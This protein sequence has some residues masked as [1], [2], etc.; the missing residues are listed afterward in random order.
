MYTKEEFLKEFLKTLAE[1]QK[2]SGQT[3]YSVS[4]KLNH[5]SDYFSKVLKGEKDLKLSEFCQ[6]CELFHITPREFFE[7]EYPYRKVAYRKVYEK[8]QSFSP[9]SFGLLRDFVEMLSLYEEKIRD[10]NRI[11]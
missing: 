9:D 7:D 5:P 11:S 2:L 6:I 1:K 8:I 10:K 3:R 4:C